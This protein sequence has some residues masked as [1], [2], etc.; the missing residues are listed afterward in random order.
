MSYLAQDYSRRKK[1]RQRYLLLPI[2][3]LVKLQL[4]IGV[5]FPKELLADLRARVFGGMAGKQHWMGEGAVLE[6]CDM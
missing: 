3:I 2:M 6:I 1:H 5:S 4:Q